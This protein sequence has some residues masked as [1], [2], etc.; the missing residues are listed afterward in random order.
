MAQISALYAAED[1][2]RFDAVTKEMAAAGWIKADRDLTVKCMGEYGGMDMYVYVPWGIKSFDRYDE[3]VRHSMYLRV[4]HRYPGVY[5][6]RAY[7]ME[8]YDEFERRWLLSRFL[9]DNSRIVPGN[10]G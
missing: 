4:V 3:W 10:D 6:D 2:K 1:R 8:E 7:I 9:L 5:Q